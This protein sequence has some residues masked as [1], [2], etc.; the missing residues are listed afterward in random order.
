MKK[1]LK[2]AAV[3]LA[4]LLIGFLVFFFGFASS[5]VEKSLNPVLNKPPYQVSEKARILHERLLIADLHADS[6]LWNRDLLEKSENGQVDVPKLLAGNVAL[7]AFTVVTKSPRGLNIERNDDR[8]DNIFWLALAQRQPLENLSSLT[9]RATWQAARLREYAARSNGKLVVIR[10]KRELTDFLEKRKT[11]KAVGGFLGIEGAHALDGKLE[12][13]DVLFDAGF[14]MMSPAHFFDSEMGGSMHGVEKYGLTEKGR[15]M[16]RRMEAKRMIVDLA[17]ASS[18]TIDDVLAIATRPVLVSH[19]GVRG[20]CDNQRN[21]SDEQLKRIAATGGLIGIGFWDTAVCGEDVA[22]I[23]RAIRHAANAIGVESVALG[24]DFD[25]SVK[26]PF[27]TSGEALVT[28][29]LLNENFSEDE[30]ARIMGGNVVR[31]LSENLPD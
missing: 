27:D 17:H 22:S 23:A 2:I 26:V 21:L 24:S 15:E 11:E 14:R 10:T 19:T 13:I 25:G 8:T 4:V 30:I 6:L 16:I 1:V 7:Q 20:T 18:R 29:A 12:N 28:E 3:V 31:F 5:V 9:N